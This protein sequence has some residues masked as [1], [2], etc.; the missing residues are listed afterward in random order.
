MRYALK[1]IGAH[2]K[3]MTVGLVAIGVLVFAV[4]AIR[5]PSN[6]KPVWVA[7]ADGGIGDCL[8][9]VSPVVAMVPPEAITADSLYGTEL[10]TTARLSI[11]VRSGAILTE[12]LL[13]GS[14]TTRSLGKTQVAIPLIVAQSVA[15]GIAVGDTIDV[16]GKRPNCIEGDCELVRLVTSAQVLESDSIDAEGW[17]E[18]EQA[19]VMLVIDQS[20]VGLALGAAAEQSAHF[21]LRHPEQ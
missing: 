1:E 18:S 17:G 9:A 7:T 11:P 19:R 3:I 16:W 12:S 4:L 5:Q 13:T 8:S 6:L 15:Q 20:E 10:P 21:V 2:L 14:P